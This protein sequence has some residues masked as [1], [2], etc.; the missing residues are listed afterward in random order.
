MSA[1]GNAVRAA[2]S[3]GRGATSAAA[4]RSV[5]RTTFVCGVIAIG[6]AIVTVWLQNVLLARFFP[7]MSRLATEFSPAYFR[8]EVDSLGADP[9]RVVFLGDSIVWGF[10]LPPEATAVSLLRAGGCACVNLAYKHGS[11]SNYYALVRILQA[12]RVRPR[13]VVVE[14]NRAGFSPVSSGYRTLAGSV[15]RLAE[16]LLDQEDRLV[17]RSEPEGARAKLDRAL[18]S[19]SLLYAM[20]LDIH[21]AL[22]GDNDPDP[23]P[24]G[25]VLIRRIF[26]LPPLDR[27]NVSVRYLEKT[28]AAL[29]RA[30]TPVLA[31]MVPINHAALDA[32]VDRVRY[33]R[34]SAYID[35]LLERGGAHVLNLDSAFP[36][37]EF[38]DEAHLNASGQRRLASIIA[39]SLRRIGAREAVLRAVAEPWKG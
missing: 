37:G 21:E 26:D 33:R 31:F 36:A 35:A 11:P 29:G 15:A 18:A 20:R 10:R 25:P 32:Y 2:A 28:L 4:S 12:Y 7:Q 23:P 30:D 19:V 5:V 8:R 3:P 6:A 24:L 22:Y 38:V 17:L 1:N 14:V 34:N 39:D 13:A 9:A 16:P 27:S